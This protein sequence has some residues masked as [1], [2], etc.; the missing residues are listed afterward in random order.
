MNELFPIYMIIFQYFQYF[1]KTI[2]CTHI[3]QN[4]KQ[5][6]GCD[7]LTVSNELIVK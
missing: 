3:H 7:F 6:K 4:Q 5:Q 2:S 1:L